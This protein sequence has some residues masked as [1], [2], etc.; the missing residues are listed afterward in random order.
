MYFPLD[1][2]NTSKNLKPLI[3]P[4][5]TCKRHYYKKEKTFHC[6]RIIMKRQI[7]YVLVEIIMSP[8]PHNQSKTATLP[9]LKA[10]YMLGYR[11]FLFPKNIQSSA[12]RQGICS[13]HL[14]LCLTLH[15][16]FGY[17]SRACIDL[18]INVYI[19]CWYLLVT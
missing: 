5:E 9:L 18:K 4:S 2:Q 8:S 6:F 14:T 11:M 19:F 15:F 10:R 7:S 13:S 3:L 17:Y 16:I 1:L 12:F